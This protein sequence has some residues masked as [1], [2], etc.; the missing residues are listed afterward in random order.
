[1]KICFLSSLTISSETLVKAVET[2]ENEWCGSII[3]LCLSNCGK[4]TGLISRNGLYINDFCLIQEDATES[5]NTAVALKDPTIES[6]VIE[7]PVES[8]LSAGLGYEY[9]Q[10]GIILNLLD[11]KQ[12]YYTYDHIRDI[13]DIAYA[14]MVVAEQV[15]DNGHAILNA[16]EKLIM[17]LRDRVWSNIALFSKNGS[18]ADF[19]KHIS[20]NGTGILFENGLITIYDKGQE[21]VVL[22]AEKIPVLHSAENHVVD[23]VL[24]AVMALHLSDVSIDIIRN[25]LA[26]QDFQV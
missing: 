24:A 20:N 6:L 17:D 9:A 5:K 4:K 8:I 25:V 18:N 19:V 13:E 15:Y 11:L 16:D 7:I 26:S 2:V 12:E 3:N 22:S 21:A 1:M 10:F 14:K 23:A